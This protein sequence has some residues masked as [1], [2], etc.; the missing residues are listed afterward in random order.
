MGWD[1]LLVTF[2]S[3]LTVSAISLPLLIKLGHRWKLLDQPGRH[4][5]H[6][7]PV[8]YLGGVAL[9]GGIW[10]AL[11]VGALFDNAWLI[12]N[13][14]RLFYVFLGACVISLVGLADDLKPLSARIKLAAQVLV[15]VMLYAGGLSVELLTTPYGSVD[16]GAASLIITV[17]WV[18]TLTNAL[19]LIDGLDGLAGGVSLIAAITLLIIGQMLNAGWGVL[20]IGGLTGFL[21]GFLIYNRYPARIFL[22][23]SGSMQLGYY[24]AVFSLLAPLKSFTAS[25]LYLPLL[26]LGVPLLETSV[27]FGRRILAGKNVMQADHRH[28][29]H[30][31]AMAGLSPRKVVLVFYVLGFVF[32]GFAIGMLLWNRVLVLVVLAVFMVV[33]LLAFFILV[34]GLV[35]RRRR[36]RRTADGPTVRDKG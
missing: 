1:L 8:P 34:A 4:K 11:I 13:S 16:V 17:L 23:D 36:E 12:G 3:S 33:I 25:A 21:I 15:G 29:F 19:N 2:V 26:A 27:S 35:S 28:L 20:F 18:V 31:L 24:F 32:S 14:G 9:F 7:R 30:F 5:R 6:K 10:I 22:G